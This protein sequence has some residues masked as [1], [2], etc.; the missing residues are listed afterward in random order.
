MARPAGGPQLPAGRACDMIAVS[1]IPKS[2]D[3]RAPKD[4]RRD[5]R[6]LLE[7]VTSPTSRCRARCR[8]Q[9]RRSPQR[10]CCAPPIGRCPPISNSSSS[11]LTSG[12]SVGHN[13]YGC[14]TEGFCRGVSAKSDA[15]QFFL[16][17][18][19]RGP[20]YQGGCRAIRLNWPSGLCQHL[21]HAPLHSVAAGTQGPLS[22]VVVSEL[23]VDGSARKVVDVD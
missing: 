5:A 11:S 10:C 14:K 17:H 1:S 2:A 3:D 16:A 20:G 13:V 22:G 23:A 9:G 7:A 18:F 15:L 21:V 8:R 19:I 4:D 6:S 12:R